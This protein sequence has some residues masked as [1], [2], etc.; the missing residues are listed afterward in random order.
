MMK[1]KN[2]LGKQNCTDY[3]N[4]SACV[5]QGD[6]YYKLHQPSADAY[7]NT[8]L[9]QL[10][11]S[12]ITTVLSSGKEKSAISLARPLILDVNCNTIP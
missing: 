5:R 4:I 3:C 8:N 2:E 6:Y 11:Y 7:N 12:S 10:K 1:D 9:L